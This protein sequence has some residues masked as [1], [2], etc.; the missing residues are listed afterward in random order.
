MRKL[1]HLIF[2][3]SLLAYTSCKKEYQVVKAVNVPEAVAAFNVKAALDYCV[4][5][6]AQAV[7]H[8]P[9]NKLPYFINNTGYW[10]CTDY[11]QW[12][13]GFW[14]GI[15]WY[16][17][18]YTKDE[19]WKTKAAT[20]T[21]ILKPVAFHS[22]TSHDIGFKINNSFGNGYRLTNDNNY[23]RILIAGADSL[24]TLFNPKVGTILSWPDKVRNDN[25][26]YNTIIDNMMNLEILFEASKF[27]SNQ[28]LY[29]I[30]VSHATKTMQNQ[31]RDDYSTYHVVF[32]NK[33]TGEKVRTITWQG[34]SDNSMWTRG[35]AWAIYGFTMCYRETGN[36]DFLNTA[37]NAANIYLKRL[38]TDEIPYWDFDDPAIPHAPRDASA[39]AI[40]ASALLELSRYVHNSTKSIFLKKK[41]TEMLA[42]L[43]TPTYKSGGNSDAFIQHSTGNKPGNQNVDASLIYADYYYL[44]ALL[45][46]F[47]MP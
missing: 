35:Q 6:T 45:R 43:S 47:R 21:Q 4:A 23:K 37:L 14:P 44:E 30:A 12:T 1:I 26:L 22:A 13:S 19:Q 41:A 2:Y 28:K 11:T 7:Q 8:V 24:A 9:Q 39:A 34:Y 10:Q 15:L 46:L 29:N 27:S 5:K 33:Q 18:D 31:F 38:P 32:Y 3:V 16:V 42:V 17:Y 40:T 20:Y 25:W 36:E